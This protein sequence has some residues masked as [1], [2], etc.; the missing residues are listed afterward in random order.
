MASLDLPALPSVPFQTFS[1]SLEGVQVVCD[2]RWN[3]REGAWY[4]DMHADDE[5]QTPIYHG[6]KVVLGAFLGERA[7][8]PLR[9]IGLLVAEDTSGEHVEAALDDL[10]TR[11]VLRFY[12]LA[13]IET[14]IA[15]AV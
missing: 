11:V 1:T 7:T 4:L 10:G 14:M 15:E 13:D 8:S 3:G 6:V 9:P 12:P 5:D 2:L